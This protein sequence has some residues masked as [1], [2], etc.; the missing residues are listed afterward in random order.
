MQLKL[1]DDWWHT[2]F[3]DHRY[4]TTRQHDPFNTSN[5]PALKCRAI[6]AFSRLYRTHKSGNL[7]QVNTCDGFPWHVVYYSSRCVNHGTHHRYSLG[8]VQRHRVYAPKQ[9]RKYIISS[10]TKTYHKSMRHA[11]HAHACEISV[12][13][14]Q[15]K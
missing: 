15:S 2:S 7:Y 5:I 4:M 11:L 12:C 9:N 6:P 13:L 10:K 1:T 3:M 14:C 8:C